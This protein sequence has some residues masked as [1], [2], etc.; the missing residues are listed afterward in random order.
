MRDNG[1]V[2]G[3][4]RRVGIIQTFE[5]GERWT[6]GLG[7]ALEAMGADWVPIEARFLKVSVN[8]SGAPVV[9]IDGDPDL[10]ETCIDDLRLDSIVWRVSEADFYNYANVF[11]T[12]ADTH[13]MVNDW[14]CIWICSDK[15]RTSARLAGWGVPVVPTVLLTPGMKVPEFPGFKTVVKPSVGASGNGVRLEPPGSK[16]V[17]N[18]PHVAQPLVPGPSCDHIRVIVCGEEPVASIHRIPSEG[19]RG[20]EI[21]VNNVAAGGV[22]ARAPMEPV[23]NIA[24]EV[25]RQL[26]G[27]IIGI[28]LVPWRG[29]FA[30]LEV[31]SSPGFNLI[32][33]TL[34]VN[35][36][37]QAA[38][39]VLRRVGGLDLAVH[40]PLVPSRPRRLS[41]T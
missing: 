28:D 9:L 19:H 10:E 34:G 27:D 17:I 11:D 1:N 6:Y 30:V 33:E 8:E 23:R 7:L 2:E 20:H 22:P 29:G 24:V 13:L 12:L 25:A 31:N 4:S 40:E 32:E 39:Q 18:E 16:P 3:T 41:K 14:R 15:W 5:P 37:W 35:C 26:G 21:E 38:E 36:F